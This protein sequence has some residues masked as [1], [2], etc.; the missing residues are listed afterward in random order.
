MKSIWEIS[1]YTTTDAQG[2]CEF[3]A[4]PGRYVIGAGRVYFNEIAKAKDVKGLF[5]DG[6]REF[7]IKA[8]KDIEI[9]LHREKPRLTGRR[10]SRPVD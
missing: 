7:E 5:P 10:R 2:V 4:A 8:Q 6:P 9:N 3:D 1:V